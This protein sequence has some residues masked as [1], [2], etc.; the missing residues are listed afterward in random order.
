MFNLTKITRIFKE[1]PDFS[2]RRDQER[3]YLFLIFITLASDLLFVH[4]KRYSFIALQHLAGLPLYIFKLILSIISQETL[5]LCM[6]LQMLIAFLLLIPSAIIYK[7]IC[8]KN[9][10][11]SI[12]YFSTKLFVLSSFFIT[13]IRDIFN[14]FNCFFNNNNS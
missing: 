12:L 2:K 8:T 14:G 5:Q 11:Y 13:L 6:G 9:C 3:V 4:M 10:F 1:R 7:Y